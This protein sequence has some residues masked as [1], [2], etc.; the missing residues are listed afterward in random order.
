MNKLTALEILM[1]QTGKKDARNTGSVR[2]YERHVVESEMVYRIGLMTNDCELIRLPREMSW[3]P[4]SFERNFTDARSLRICCLLQELILRHVGHNLARCAW[5]TLLQNSQLWRRPKVTK[6]QSEKVFF[7]FVG[8]FNFLGCDIISR[9]EFFHQ[10]IRLGTHLI[11]RTVTHHPLCFSISHLY[12]QHWH[13]ADY[14]LQQLVRMFH[15]LPVHDIVALPTSCPTCTTPQQFN[16]ETE[17]RIV[18]AFL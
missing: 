13:C 7:L 16:F 18:H 9:W 5:I 12:I 3:W 14:C 10:Q 8:V 4:F 6:V 17:P 15:F 2:E 1:S 11:Q